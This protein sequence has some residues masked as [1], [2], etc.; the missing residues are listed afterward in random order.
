MA[1]HRQQS[2][3][4][5][6]AILDTNLNESFVWEALQMPGNGV[7]RIDDRPLHK[8]HKALAMIGDAHMR[9]ILVESFYRRGLTPGLSL[10]SYLMCFILIVVETI[11]NNA[12]SRL[13]NEDL[14]G[15][16]DRL[17]L[18]QYININPAN[19]GA[20]GWQ[21]KAGT[22]EA[23]IGAAYLSGGSARAREIMTVMGLL[24]NVTI[25]SHIPS[26]HALYNESRDKCI[27]ADAPGVVDEKAPDAPFGKDFR[28]TH[29]ACLEGTIPAG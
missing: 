26:F 6:R 14:A 2:V 18:T 24:G 22:V 25:L 9:A 7:A 21:V 4:A 23:L 15:V 1:V 20:I 8:G 19:R 10:F 3:T 11:N 28:A 5:V 17:G 13:G 12:Q 27:Y 29:L 16:C